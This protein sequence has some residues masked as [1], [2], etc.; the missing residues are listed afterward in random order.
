MALVGRP[1]RTGLGPYRLGPNWPPWALMP[2]WA[3][4]RPNGLGPHV[5]GLQ[6]PQGPH[7][8]GH[9]GLGP[10]GPGPSGLGPN[11][12]GP[13]G[14]P[15]ALMGQALMGRALVGPLALVGPPGSSCSGPNGLGR[16]GPKRIWALMGPL[17]L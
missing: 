4:L 2:S 6:G 16:I 11:G 12:P 13:P 17:G 9:N 1:C 5:S 15:Q 10:H 3:S 8:P 7:G 14:P